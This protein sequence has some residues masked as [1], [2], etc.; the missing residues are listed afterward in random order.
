[1]ATTSSGTLITAALMN[2][3]NS[4]ATISFT[5]A[6]GA[7]RIQDYVGNSGCF[8]SHRPN[9]ALLVSMPSIK[10]GAFGGGHFYIKKYVDGAWTTLKSWSWGWN[11]NTSINFN[12]TG[13]GYYQVYSSDWAMNA[14]SG[15]IYCGDTACAVGGKIRLA[16]TWQTNS[17]GYISGG[18]I[19]ADLA[20]TH[21][22]ICQDGH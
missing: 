2:S 17:G 14:I 13:P 21:Y 1:M 3:I 20:N 5:V 15:T 9:G 16:N 18:L 12:S 4:D 6:K 11:T 19:T 8:Y 7:D 22:R 10:C